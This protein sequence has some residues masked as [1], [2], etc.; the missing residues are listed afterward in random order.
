MFC[1]ARGNLKLAVGPATHAMDTCTAYNV[2][3]VRFIM[4]YTI[5]AGDIWTQI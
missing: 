3:I 5:Y 2:Y 4:Y 1:P